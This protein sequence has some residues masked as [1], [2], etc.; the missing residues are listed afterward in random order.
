MEHGKVQ[1]ALKNFPNLC[2][3]ILSYSLLLKS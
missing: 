2:L 1:D 3:P